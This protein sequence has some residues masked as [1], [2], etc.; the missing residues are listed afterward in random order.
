MIEQDQLKELTENHDGIPNL[1]ENN[2][3][4]WAISIDEQ[5]FPPQWYSLIRKRWMYN[6]KSGVSPR[7]LLIRAI[8]IE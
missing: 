3:I 5:S 4:F 6:L 7:E 2:R 1:I 8:S